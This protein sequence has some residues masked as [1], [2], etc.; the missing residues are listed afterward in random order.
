MVKTFAVAILLIGCAGNTYAQQE[1]VETPKVKKIDHVVGA[2]INGLI[3]QVFN[4]NNT[5]TAVGNPYLLT[6]NINFRKSGW[7]ARVGVGY[8][9]SSS[10]NN[11]GITDR[12][13][14]I[15]DKQVRLGGEKAF[16]LSKKWSAGVG[17]DVLFNDNN[18]HTKSTVTSF[19]TVV[20]DTKSKVTSYGAGPMS[21]LRYHI[22]DKIMIG[23]EASF[24][25]LTGDQD[26]TI[27]VTRRE[28]TVGPGS[29][30]VTKQTRSK[31]EI[32]QGV[33]SLPVVFY[34]AV[35]F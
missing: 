15:N 24:Y 35:K 21:W 8:N 26:Q 32:S 31:P 19:D 13:S 17:L 23:T 14:K 29:T 28:F 1:V 27:T 3:R 9:Y 7:G 33:I 22:S 16:S 20:T 18:D 34:L 30:I 12:I 11:D 2:Q 4:F 25:Y 10:A 6:Y 5:T